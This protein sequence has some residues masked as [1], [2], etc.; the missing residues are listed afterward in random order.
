MIGRRH[1]PLRGKRFVTAYAAA[2]LYAIVRIFPG[3]HYA[4]ISLDMLHFFAD[5]RHDTC[6]G[7]LARF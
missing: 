6:L 1:W 4:P 2:L 7:L 5:N 3:R